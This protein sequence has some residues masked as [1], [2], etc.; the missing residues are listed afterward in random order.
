M[1]HPGKYLFV[2]LI[3]FVQSALAQL[4]SFSPLSNLR[5]KAILIKAD[6]VKLDSFS[7][8]P[9]SVSIENVSPETYKIDAVNATLSWIKKP[10]SSF[11]WI[12]YR[13][14]PFK[15]NA[16]VKHYNYDSVRYNFLNNSPVTF[17]TANKQVNPLFG[18]RYFIRQQ[19][20][21]GG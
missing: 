21:C 11:V 3:V 20:G 9:N 14:F 7:I 18:P 12:T 4:P 6:K 8:V 2:I 5:K 1:K 15:L 19:P 10:D 16:T 17:S 13:I